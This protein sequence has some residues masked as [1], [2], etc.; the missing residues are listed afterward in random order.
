VRREIPGACRRYINH[1]FLLRLLR[2]HH[3][4]DSQKCIKISCFDDFLCF[5]TCA[6]FRIRVSANSRLPMRPPPATAIPFRFPPPTSHPSR[7]HLP[8]H[9]GLPPTMPLSAPNLSAPALTTKRVHTTRLFGAVCR[10]PP[11]GSA[12]ALSF[13]TCERLSSN[14]ES[15][16]VVRYRGWFR[17][18]AVISSHR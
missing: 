6:H 1:F 16:C 12:R 7:R 3:L 4:L 13:S 5:D 11:A 8:V 2:A 10:R 15:K 18:Y 14:S 17:A 9:R